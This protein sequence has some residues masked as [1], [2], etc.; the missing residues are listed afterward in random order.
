MGVPFMPCPR[1]GQPIPQQAAFCP[2]C[3]QS[4]RRRKPVPIPTVHRRR[5]PWGAL[6][7]LLVL[8]A[9][10]LGLWLGRERKVKLYFGVDD[11]GMCIVNRD[12][13]NQYL[14]QARILSFGDLN[15]PDPT[16][17]EALTVCYQMSVLVTYQGKETAGNE[18]SSFDTTHD[19]PGTCYLLLFDSNFHLMAY[20]LGQPR[21]EGEGRWE[22]EVTLCDYDVTPLYETQR[23]ALQAD[24]D[25]VFANPIPPEE[26]AGCGAA[27]YI[28]GNTTGRSGILLEN[29]S[30]AYYL[31]ARYTSPWR[32]SWCRPIGEL[33]GDLPTGS[34][35]ICYL[36][37]DE[38]CQ[39][40]G[41]TMVN[42]HN[43]YLLGRLA[44][45]T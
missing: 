11:T 22:M 14:P 13:V 4:V 39:L 44:E 38:D 33:A 19:S 2:H 42:G 3:A 8:A 20:F 35:W 21:Q 28:K 34:R 23:A 17:E 16:L 6:V 7:L 1:C 30:Q 45:R 40:L 27:W 36:L 31:W 10:I 18:S 26:V 15:H 43:A 12:T 29:D 32:E 24:W 25:K 41:Y 9:L 5:V 37:L